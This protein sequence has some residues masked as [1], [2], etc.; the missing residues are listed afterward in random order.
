MRRD[1]LSN[2][3]EYDHDLSTIDPDYE[4]SLTA[5]L[6]GVDGRSDY[7]DRPDYE[8]RWG[9]GRDVTSDGKLAPLDRLDDIDVAKG[10]TD[11]RGFEVVGRDGGKL[12][13]VRQLVGDVEAMKVRYLTVKLD[14]SLGKK[15]GEL[16]IPVG[17]AHIDPEEKRVR[18]PA[19]DRERAVSLPRWDGNEIPRKLETQLSSFFDE[20]Y[21]D[22][23]RYDHPRY[24]YDR[25]YGETPVSMDEATPEDEALDIIVVR[26]WRLDLVDEHTTGTRSRRSRKDAPRYDEETS[27]A[28]SRP[29]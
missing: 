6:D 9:R 29:R 4:R 19:L 23:R 26:R 25:L 18:V 3:P 24:R 20:S 16:L 1:Y 28:G 22:E 5:A 14:R 11:P 2:L 17:H 12:G 7:Y 15:D 10:D 21:G 27:G 8:T 13:K